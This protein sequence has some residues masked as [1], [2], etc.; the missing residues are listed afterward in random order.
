MKLSRLKYKTWIKCQPSHERDTHSPPTLPV[1]SKIATIGLQNGQQGLEKGITRGFRVLRPIL[2]KEVFD[3]RTHSMRKGHDRENRGNMNGT[4]A[5][6]CRGTHSPP[7]PKKA[8]KGPKNGRWG[9]GAPIN[10]LQKYIFLLK[11]PFYEKSRR[12]RKN[13]KK[14]SRSYQN[15]Y[16]TSGPVARA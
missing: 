4:P 15:K 12:R 14:K 13:E 3:L 7:A 1:K 11:H 10:F 16:E 2:I 8:P 9:L 6:R 5:W